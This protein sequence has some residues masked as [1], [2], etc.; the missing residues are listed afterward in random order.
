MGMGCAPASPEGGTSKAL[1][2]KGDITDTKKQRDIRRESARLP[3]TAVHI[4]SE[5][6]LLHPDRL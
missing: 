2:G 5:G 1:P 3:C 4:T 6:K